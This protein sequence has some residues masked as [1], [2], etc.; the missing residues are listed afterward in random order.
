M[1][2]KNFLMRAILTIPVI[3]RLIIP[4]HTKRIFAEMIK[5]EYTKVH[6]VGAP[7]LCEPI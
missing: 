4:V 1:E 6:A 3:E 2:V 7:I 5:L